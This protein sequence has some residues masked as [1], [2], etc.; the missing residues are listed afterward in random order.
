METEKNKGY[1]R[2]S[3]KVINPQQ[4]KNDLIAPWLPTECD[5]N[6]SVKIIRNSRH[7]LHGIVSFLYLDPAQQNKAVPVR[8]AFKLVAARRYVKR[9][10]IITHFVIMLNPKRMSKH[11][12]LPFL[13]AA[14][15]WLSARGY[16]A[17]RFPVV[18]R[19]RCQNFTRMLSHT[20]FHFSV[21]NRFLFQTINV[22][23]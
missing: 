3:L 14:L 7:Y 1:K 23:L 5:S 10:W 4:L 22:E 15:H 21:L 2:P 17:V 13:I 6:V 8:L 18:S 12:A 9:D 20:E 11:C 16:S 19:K